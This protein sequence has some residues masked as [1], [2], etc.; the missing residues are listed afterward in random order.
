MGSSRRG[1]V[2]IRSPTSENDGDQV[3]N[4]R[5]WDK[6]LWP[7]RLGEGPSARSVWQAS[8]DEATL[9]AIRGAGEEDGQSR[10][11]K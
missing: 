4:M 10:G 1:L 3:G 11:P 5:A 6:R 2:D 9:K 7:I 8:K